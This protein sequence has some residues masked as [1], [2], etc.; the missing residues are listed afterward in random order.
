MAQVEQDVIDAQVARQYVVV[1]RQQ[2]AA[3]R[4]DGV[5]LGEDGLAAGVPVRGLHYGGLEQLE[6]YSQS[7]HDACNHYEGIASQDVLLVVSFCVFGHC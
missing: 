1:V 2:V 6:Q 3:L 4:S 5:Y 7:H